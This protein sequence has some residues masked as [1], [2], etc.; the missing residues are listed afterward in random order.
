MLPKIMNRRLA[1]EAFINQPTV[2]GSVLK[3]RFIWKDEQK[4]ILTDE[5]DT[6][7]YSLT[8]SNPCPEVQKIVKAEFSKCSAGFVPSTVTYS[9]SSSERFI[10]GWLFK[11]HCTQKTSSEQ[12]CSL[13]DDKTI[14][15]I[16]EGKTQGSIA[17]DKFIFA[18]T[19]ATTVQPD[20][21][22]RAH[23]N[24]NTDGNVSDTVDTNDVEMLCTFE[25]DFDKFDRTLR[26]LSEVNR[27]LPLLTGGA[28]L[29]A[30]ELDIVPSQHLS[31]VTGTEA[32]NLVFYSALYGQSD[33]YQVTDMFGESIQTF[34]TAVVNG[35]RV[36]RELPN[37]GPALLEQLLAP[38][39]YIRESY[40]EVQFALPIRMLPSEGW[41]AVSGTVLNG[42]FTD[43]T[44][45]IYENGEEKTF[46]PAT[47]DEVD[48][49][50]VRYSYLLW[51][52]MI[53]GGVGFRRELTS[54]QLDSPPNGENAYLSNMLFTMRVKSWSPPLMLF[55]LHNMSQRNEKAP[56]WLIET[57]GRELNLYPVPRLWTNPEG[58]EALV[59]QHCSTAHEGSKLKRYFNDY[60]ISAEADICLCY[61]SRVGP[62]ANVPNSAASCFDIHCSGKN[63]G[64]QVDCSSK[65]DEVV[66]WL[67]TDQSLDPTAVNVGRLKL[68]CG[69]IV[70]EPFSQQQINVKLL[71]EGALLS[72]ALGYAIRGIPVLAVIV[73]IIGLCLS[74]Y[75]ATR[76]V[77]QPACK[78]KADGTLRPA[79]ISVKTGNEI[80][81]LFC[82]TKK[83]CDCYQDS[84][85][86]PGEVCVSGNC[87]SSSD[88]IT[89]RTSLSQRVNTWDI[90]LL[91]L[92]ALLIASSTRNAGG[93]VMLLLV[94]A[95]SLYVLLAPGS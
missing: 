78:Q 57:W 94:M 82:P 58:S 24:K 77:G 48:R 70:P 41:K 42:M 44:E 26:S 63:I 51:S 5:Y 30:I 84:M 19:S 43:E 67:Q 95:A 36:S 52:E 93:I 6:P 29:D 49:S 65:C 53:T 55:V 35:L 54:S 62:T 11:Y 20:C 86:A 31:I 33:D 10:D 4:S 12:T 71:I 13:P 85:C 47:Y 69:T 80:P 90:L 61:Y 17:N 21:T 27:W 73:T 79:C 89:I 39:S 2:Q 28:R 14:C 75:V 81:Q 76:L 18:A 32:A 22:W 34:T 46:D 72:L 56:M 1:T 66:D 25:Y 7:E 37:F 15:L 68:V 9:T 91:A 59:Q 60:I 50:N 38:M 64:R 3:E 23:L 83:K 88:P 92:A 45:R 74:T 87:I 16:N 8:F 40:V